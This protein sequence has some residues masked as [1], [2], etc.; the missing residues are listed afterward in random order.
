MTNTGAWGGDWR[1]RAR[2]ESG[3]V[4]GHWVGGRGLAAEFEAL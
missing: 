4:K 3:F 1:H 2:W